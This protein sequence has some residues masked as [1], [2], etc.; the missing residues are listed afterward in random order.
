[1]LFYIQGPSLI[2]RG[3]WTVERRIKFVNFLYNPTSPFLPLDFF[4]KVKSFS[5]LDK[6]ISQNKNEA[7]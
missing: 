4:F 6:P 1:M 5:F 7:N 3:L 2:L